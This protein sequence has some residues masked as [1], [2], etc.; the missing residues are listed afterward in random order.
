MPKRVPRPR[1]RKG[2]GESRA[3]RFSEFEGE[4]LDFVGFDLPVELNAAGQLQWLQFSADPLP[5]W[6]EADLPAIAHCCFL[7]GRLSECD[8]ADAVSKISRE[9][10]QVEDSL[11][12]TPMSRARMA[13]RQPPAPAPDVSVRRRPIP[14]DV[15]LADAD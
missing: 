3:G 10:R 8:S 11:G 6:T 7:F 5:W 15:L 4:P 13:L 12:M 9:L 14:V 2:V 1:L